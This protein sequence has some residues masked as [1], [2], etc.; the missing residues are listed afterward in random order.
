MISFSILIIFHFALTVSAT[1][2]TMPISRAS[3]KNRPSRLR[4]VQHNTIRTS[5]TLTTSFLDTNSTKL[6]NT[7]DY[8]FT[9]KIK[10]GT[11]QV[12]KVELD[13]G[14][15]D[16]WLRGPS[17][18]SK[19]GSCG[20]NAVKKSMQTGVNLN[21]KSMKPMGKSFTIEYGTGKVT[22]KV[23]NTTVSIQGINISMPIGVSSTESDFKD[24][25]GLLG[26]SFPKN[27]EIK[28]GNFIEC[29]GSAGLKKT[30]GF[31]LSNR[32]NG[33]EGE[34]TFGGYDSTKFTG[35]ITWL[36]VVKKVY[37]GFSAD[38]WTYQIGK[39][40]GKLS[41]TYIADT[42]TSLMT[43]PDKMAAAINTE[44]GGKL[45]NGDYQ[46]DCNLTTTGPNLIIKFSGGTF[47]VPPNICKRYHL[48]CITFSF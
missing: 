17:C 22:G 47:T 37:W 27:N 15:A 20:K 28:G 16:L 43:V 24:L 23:Y 41:G 25:D 36:P 32:A 1:T 4:F 18:T 8:F 40:S 39:T 30:F 21:H 13:T 31:Y 12:F 11:G 6:S 2:L 44:I 29:A 33:D 45:Q 14:S 7:G 38:G 9:A 3:S 34:F 35:N 42:G 10:I 5:N 26:L 48:L 46:L 19:D